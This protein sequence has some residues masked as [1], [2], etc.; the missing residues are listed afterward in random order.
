MT[1]F[2]KSALGGMFGAQNSNAA[3]P[4]STT[5]AA[6]NGNNSNSFNAGKFFQETAPTNDFV[7]QTIMIGSYKLRIKKLL[8][9]GEFV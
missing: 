2:F 1:D 7:G 6:N 9:E 4:S 8:A 5:S 3:T